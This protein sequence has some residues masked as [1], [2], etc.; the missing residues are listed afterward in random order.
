MNRSVRVKKHPQY[1]A[2]KAYQLLAKL[3]DEDMANKLGMSK[4]TYK[5]KINGYADF[6]S[7][8]GIALSN[9]FNKPQEEIFLT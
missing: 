3:S 1:Y 9:I 8:E 2:I 7:A 6:S 5:D 4:R